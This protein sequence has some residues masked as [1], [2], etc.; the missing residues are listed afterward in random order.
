MYI[1]EKL[2][3]GRCNYFSDLFS[4]G[5]AEMIQKEEYEE[6]KILFLEHL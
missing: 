5:K 2:A 4:N 3:D 1:Q 6:G